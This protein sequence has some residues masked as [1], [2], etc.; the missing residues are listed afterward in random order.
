MSGLVIRLTVAVGLLVLG[1][2]LAVVA[3][4]DHGEAKEATS[5]RIRTEMAGIAAVLTVSADEES[6]RTALAR[7]G[8]RIAVQLPGGKVVG[9]SPKTDE[10]VLLLPLVLSDGGRATVLAEVPPV[11]FSPGLGVRLLILVVTGLATV[12]GSVVLVRRRVRPSVAALRSVLGA[13]KSLGQTGVASV[14]VPDAPVELQRLAHALGDLGQQWSALRTDERKVLADVSHRLRT[15]L[16]ALRLDAASVTDPVVA[17]R[18]QRSLEDLETEI[19]R[20]ISTSEPARAEPTGPVDLCEEVRT[21][22]L[23]WSSMAIA[24]DRECTVT[25]EAAPA[26]VDVPAD[27][28]VGALDSLLVNVFQHT[29]SGTPLSVEVVV[30]AGWATV[31]VDDGGPGIA[32]PEAALR[33]GSSGAGST[34]LGLDIARR[35]VERVGGSIHLERSAFGGARIRLRVPQV[36]NAQPS[37]PE[38]LAWRMWRNRGSEVYSGH[39]RTAAPRRG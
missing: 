18:L 29:E 30:H 31:V 27:E 10:D 34:G 8:D 35:T 5:G 26:I 36:G 38:P 3:V 11:M 6:I 28:L 17:E 1:V 13:A 9:A 2:L 14:S 16:T 19:T 22:M 32:E 4:L 7:T 24:Q 39:R 33:R 20:I 23:F 15:P 25:I 12:A 21:R 37:R